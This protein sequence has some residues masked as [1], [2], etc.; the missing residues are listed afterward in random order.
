MQAIAF[1][2]CADSLSLH[3]AIHPKTLFFY[4]SLFVQSSQSCSARKQAGRKCSNASSW[5]STNRNEEQRH[6]WTKGPFG[7]PVSKCLILK[8]YQQ[9]WRVEM[10]MEK[11]YF[12]STSCIS[13]IMLSLNAT[14]SLSKKI[15]L[16]MANAFIFSK[17]LCVLKI[18]TVVSRHS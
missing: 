5:K 16:L 10:L 15:P 1:A 8:I 18:S 11:G 17:F 4:S 2:A 7:S 14:S 3:R 9:K 12:G 6:W 13:R